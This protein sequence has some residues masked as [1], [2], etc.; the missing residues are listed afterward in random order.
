MNE[1]YNRVANWNNQRYDRQYNHALTLSLL[2]EEF[3]EWYD[4]AT[5]VD[6]VDAM[7]DVVYVAF[8]ALWKLKLSDNA[9][10]QVMNQCLQDAFI[11]LDNSVIEPVHFIAA[12]L[13]SMHK[14]SSFEGLARI[15]GFGL[16]QLYHMGFSPAEAVEAL[17]IVC[18]SND[19]KSVKKTD[20]SVKANAGDKGAGFIAPEPRLQNLLDHVQSHKNVQ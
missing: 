13:A 19:S 10:S 17:Q 8:G 6:R 5:D 14:E 11:I 16:G 15:I 4:S 7:C 20:S 2:T 9:M 12:E 1:I 3:G 18:D